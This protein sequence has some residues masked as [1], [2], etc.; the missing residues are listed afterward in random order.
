MRVD[1]PRFGEVDVPEDTILTFPCGI[2]G[3]PDV[4]DCCLFPYQVGLPLRWLQCLDDTRV[5]FL[6]VEPHAFLP[7]YEIELAETDAADLSLERA[8]QAA[9]IT[10]VTLLHESR[11]VA[12]NLVAPIIINMETRRAKQVLLNDDR[13]RTRHVI[14]EDWGA[15]NVSLDQKAR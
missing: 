4:R 7:D 3:F 11:A 12:T 15:D 2:Y 14:I 10:L 9:V 6:T 8:S 5:A 13:Y 1:T